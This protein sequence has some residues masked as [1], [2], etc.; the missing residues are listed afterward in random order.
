MAPGI[1]GKTPVLVH[2]GF[3]QALIPQL[4]GFQQILFLQVLQLNRVKAQLAHLWACMGHLLN[5]R[6]CLLPTMGQ[7]LL[8]SICS[9]ATISGLLL[10]HICLQSAMGI[11]FGPTLKRHGLLG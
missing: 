11:L 8:K 7:I 2:R 3:S 6:Q 5:A 10:A 4:G 1:T 9:V